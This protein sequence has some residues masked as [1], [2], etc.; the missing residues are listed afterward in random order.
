MK[1]FITKRY[2]KRVNA[3]RQPEP[4]RFHVEQ[5]KGVGTDVH[6]T[7]TMNP[8]LRKHPDLR[9]AMLGHEVHEIKEWGKGGH[10]AHAKSHRKE[11]KLTRGIGG[12]SGFW[13]E[14]KRREK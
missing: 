3:G 1:I 9:K 2:E 10:A 8:V 13:K 14:I 7:I 12:V 11:P 5:P 6:A 4:I